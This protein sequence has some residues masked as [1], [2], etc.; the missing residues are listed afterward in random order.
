MGAGD[1]MSEGIPDFSEAELKQVTD[2]LSQRY[3][4]AVAL[5]LADSEL[6]FGAGEALTSCPTLYWSERGAHFV[7][8]R[9]AKDRYRCQFYYSEAEQYG[10][11]RPEYDDLGECVLTLLRVQ[12]DHERAKALSGVPAAGDD[13]YR[14]PVII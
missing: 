12:A 14:G 7:V 9:V 5:E 3:G 11:G 8:C 4:K 1:E 6:Q 13:E 2:L 10:T